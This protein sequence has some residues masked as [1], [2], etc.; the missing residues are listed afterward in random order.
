MV[1]GVEFVVSSTGAV[2]QGGLVHFQRSHTASDVVGE[3]ILVGLVAEGVDVDDLVVE[4]KGHLPQMLVDAELG[5]FA[6]RHV[7]GIGG[8]VCG[9][10]EEV[11]LDLAGGAADD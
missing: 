10:V 9:P 11:E 5:D 6:I 3:L 8:R 4:P 1:E 2:V 7:D